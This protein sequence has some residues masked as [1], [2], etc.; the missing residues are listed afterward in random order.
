MDNTRTGERR[1]TYTF[2]EKIILKPR[3][4]V[5]LHTGTG[6]DSETQGKEPRWNLYWGR[7]AFV[8]I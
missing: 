6:K 3:D 8:W 1:H 4:D 7:H 2:P 5:V